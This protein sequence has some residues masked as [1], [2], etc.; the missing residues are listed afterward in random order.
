MNGRLLMAPAALLFALAAC[1][2]G[3][4]N[5]DVEKKAAIQKA[6][7]AQPRQTEVLK[8]RSCRTDE[9][10]WRGYYAHLPYVHVADT[11]TERNLIDSGPR[12][13]HCSTYTWAPAAHA[14]TTGR[15]FTGTPVSYVTIGRMVVDKVGPDQQT[16]AGTAVS[17]D[18]H[19]EPD[20][21]GKAMIAQRLA[22]RPKDIVDGQAV[23]HKDADGQ[24]VAGF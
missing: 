15:P 1:G 4:S 12:V 23:M 19:F 8:G 6:L 13:L 22:A 7:D 3:P 17:F 5:H 20:D 16:A 10:K 14:V 2:A 11:G 24:L 21:V 18:A 9:L